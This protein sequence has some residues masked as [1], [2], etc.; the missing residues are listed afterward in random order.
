L[1]LRTKALKLVQPRCEKF[2]N[3]PTKTPQLN[4]VLKFGICQP[5]HLKLTAFVLPRSR[6][7]CNCKQK[8]CI[9]FSRVA[10]IF[11][12]AYE[13]TAFC[14]AAQRKSLEL[15]TKALFIVQPHSE[16]LEF[17]NEATQIS[18][19][20]F[21]ALRTFLELANKNNSS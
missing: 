10:K 16:N 5:K 6:N 9:L 14:S 11:G 12:V 20:L 21:W 2:G 13:S 7:F 18:C 17:T 19:I 3:L 4:C 1:E 8:Q 15:R